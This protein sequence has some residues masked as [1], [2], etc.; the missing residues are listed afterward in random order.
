MLKRLILSL[1]LAAG[2]ISP[3]FAAGT[4]PGISMTQQ[5]DSL[6]KPLNGG[7]LYL[8]QAGTTSTPQNCYQDSGLSI[9]WPNPIT[10]DSAG[11]IPQLFCADGQIKIRLVN[12]AGVQ[13]LVA[14]NLLVVGPS[15][16][17]GGGG[18]VDPTTVLT[19]CDMKV[20]YGTGVLTG[21]VRANG[22]TI[23]SATSGA[24]ERANAD[25]LA[26]FTCLYNADANL[27]VSGGRGANAAADYAANKTIALPDWRGRAL[28]GLDDMGNSAALRL[29]STYFGTSPTVLGA[30]GGAQNFAMTL[31]NMIQ[32]T[33]ANT[34]TDPGHRHNQLGG[35]GGGVSGNLV[36]AN[37]DNSSSGAIQFTST[38]TTGITINNAAAGSASPTPMTTVQPTMLA[39]IYLKL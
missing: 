21:F 4:I 11:R 27:A 1:A 15:G 3:A 5:L 8:I 20:T 28:A 35:G 13:Q 25:T 38:N 33:H 22:R 14:D 24:T 36:F 34:L 9:A 16:G 37:G 39:T 10:L 12:A 30:A 32:H 6:G 31:A 18:S 23:G 7:K 19:S 2:L 26:L 17:G 29:T